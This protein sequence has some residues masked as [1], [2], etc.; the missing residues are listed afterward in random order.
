MTVGLF[1]R[2]QI[3]KENCEIRIVL[4]IFYRPGDL[5]YA[6]LKDFPFPGNFPEWSPDPRSSRTQIHIWY[7]L[8]K[9]SLHPNTGST[10]DGLR[11]RKTHLKHVGAI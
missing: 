2:R 5:E 7:V 10:H 4:I 9:N 6:A 3:R 1:N 8:T 11:L